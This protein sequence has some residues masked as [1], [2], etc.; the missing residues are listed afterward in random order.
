VPTG[1]DAA[2]LDQA[3]RQLARYV[4]PLARVL[5]RKAAAATREVDELYRL[6]AQELE[7]PADRRRFLD[8]AAGSAPATT[9][10][11]GSRGSGSS[12]GQ[13]PGGAV[14]PEMVLLATRQ[15]APLM[16]PIAKVVARRT[17]AQATSQE[18][19]Y[20]LL[21]EQLTDPSDRRAFLQAVGLAAGRG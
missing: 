15:L 13:A 3:Q 2:V 7:S 18:Q 14:T 6:L 12:S 1:W 11:G 16:G 10:A 17:A 9:I 8:E 5:V 4:G 21:A 20:L 19:F